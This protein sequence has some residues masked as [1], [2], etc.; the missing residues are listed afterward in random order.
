MFIRQIYRDSMLFA[1]ALAPLLAALFFRFV[2]PIAEQA[3][4]SYFHR[5]TILSDYYLLFDLFLGI[6]TPS[7]VCV[8]ASMV[9]LD[10]YDQKMVSY[11]AVTPIGK[12]GYIFS[13]LWIPVMFSFIESLLFLCFFSLTRWTVTML[14]PVCILFAFSSVITALLIFTYS[15]N[16]VEGMALSKLSGLIMAGLVVPFFIKSNAA[17]LF[18]PLPSFWIAKLCLD[19]NYLLIIPALFFSLVWLWFLYIQFNKKFS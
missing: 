18:L 4:C 5:P 2:I 13:R 15:R 16:R 11:L 8:A 7:M 9:M 6:L 12:K 3:M 1:L 19:M 17:Y 10:E 14:L